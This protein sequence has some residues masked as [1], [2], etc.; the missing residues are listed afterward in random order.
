MPK[1]NHTKSGIII[2]AA[3]NVVVI[4]KY[5]FMPSDTPFLSQDIII[6]CILLITELQNQTQREKSLNHKE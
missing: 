4:M 3:D 2:L 1:Q 6:L 5:L